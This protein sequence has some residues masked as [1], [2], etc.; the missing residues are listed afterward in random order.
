[1]IAQPGPLRFPDYPSRAR[2]LAPLIAAH[3][4]QGE[5]ERR[6]PEAVLAALFD[7]GLFRLLLPRA[8]GGA[9]V[10]PV[11]F[12]RTIE[13]VARADASAA[14]VLCQVSG[15]SMIAA[16]LEPHVA[17]K[18]FA[19]DP[20]A[21]LAWGAGPAGRAVAVEGGY[22]VSGT[23]EFASGGRHATWLGA[24]CPVHDAHGAPRLR[25]AGEPEI[26]TMLFPAAEATLQDVWHVIGL[27]ATGSDAYTVTDLFVPA[28]HSAARDDPAERREPG[29]LYCFPIGNL[30]AAGFAGV[31][32]GL[33]RSL[34]DALV[35]LAREKTPRGLAQPLAAR[36]VVQSQLAQAEARWGAARTYL[37]SSLEE[38]WRAVGRAGRLTLAQRVQ[39]R[40]AA[41][42]AI[43]EAREV[44]GW[45]YHTAGS[46]AIFEGGAFER[47][48]R[49]L[50]AVTQQVQGRH[51]HYETVGRF[52]LGLDPASPFV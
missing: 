16:S 40:L 4:E 26:R 39:I 22:R 28:A 23:W 17:R 8:L 12:V 11:T 48:F 50:H 44:A 2:A 37:L 32:L 34:L 19:D 43:H 7:A 3:A 25:G 49:D 52:L 41:T 29:P 30:F 45:A 1:V 21:V 27:R 18:M 24:H 14:W 38:I 20:R 31:A 46:G 51:A 9:E 42:H 36:A 33:A 6:L 13:A 10:D 15:S 47:R 5:R 35:A